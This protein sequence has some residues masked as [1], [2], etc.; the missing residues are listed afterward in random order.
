[1][2]SEYQYLNSLQRKRTRKSTKVARQFF[3]GLERPQGIFEKDNRV[4]AK[5]ERKRC[6]ICTVSLPKGTVGCKL[7][8][9]EFLS[10]VPSEA[11]QREKRQREWKGVD[12]L[13]R[14]RVWGQSGS[15]KLQMRH[16]STE[17]NFLPTLTLLQAQNKKCRFRLVQHI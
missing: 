10:T 2:C 5:R 6:L 16:Y 13:R 3:I 12:K 11:R 9:A 15:L 17:E 7:K 1:M 8:T 4:G 14:Q